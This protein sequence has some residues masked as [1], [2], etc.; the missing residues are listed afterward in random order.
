M[1]K[2]LHVLGGFI[3]L[4][5]IGVSCQGFPPAAVPPAAGVPAAVANAAAVHEAAAHEAASHESIEDVMT[6]AVIQQHA[7]LK[8][9]SDDVQKVKELM[10]HRHGEVEEAEEEAAVPGA[11]NDIHLD[12]KYPGPEAAPPGPEATAPEG[13][14]MVPLVIVAPQHLPDSLDLVEENELDALTPGTEAHAT[15]QLM[16]DQYEDPAARKAALIQELKETEGLA[17]YFRSDAST[18]EYLIEKENE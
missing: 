3:L 11:G 2:I 8:T 7:M 5:G 4:S 1:G 15:A 12:V 18:V 10:E 16:K 6:N 14:V 17:A 9:L 13:P